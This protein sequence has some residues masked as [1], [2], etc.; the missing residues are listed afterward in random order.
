MAVAFRMNRS[1]MDD[2]ARWCHEL[3][4]SP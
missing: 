2:S 3:P 4:S 1:M